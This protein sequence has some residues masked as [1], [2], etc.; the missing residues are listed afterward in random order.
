MPY[1]CPLQVVCVFQSLLF[2]IYSI[3]GIL[4]ESNMTSEKSIKEFEELKTNKLDY[5]WRRFRNVLY[6]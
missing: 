1:L 6:G 5:L 2:S 3:S 4:K